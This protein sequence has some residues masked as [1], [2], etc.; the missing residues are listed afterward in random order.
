METIPRAIK[1]GTSQAT[2]KLKNKKLSKLL[3]WPEYYKSSSHIQNSM[4][5][6]NI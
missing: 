3:V 6:N 4:C 2:N 1:N 5:Q